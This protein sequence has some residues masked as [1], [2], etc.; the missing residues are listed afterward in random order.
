[1]IRA[2]ESTPEND[3]E[4]PHMFSQNR[5]PARA[6]FYSFPDQEG[7]LKQSLEN[8]PYYLNL[9]GE[10]AFNFVNSPADRPKDFYQESYDVSN[11]DKIPVPSNWQM[12]GYDTAI[13]VNQ[14]Y[15]FWGIAQEKPQPPI[16]P[17]EYNPVGSY[18]RT[19]TVPENWGDRHVYIH[20]G[21]VKSAFYIWVNGK[22]VGYSEGSKTP[23][24]FDLTDYINPGNNT[25]ALEVYRW[26]SGSYLEAQDFWRLSGITRDVYLEARNKAHIY[27]FASLTTLTDQYKNGE[28]NLDFSLVNYGKSG[29][30]SVEYQLIDPDK[31]QL[32]GKEIQKISLKKGEKAQVSFSK[33]VKNVKAWSAET[34]H[35]YTL[36][37]TLKKK[38][39]VIDVISNSIGFRSVEIKGGQLLVNGKAILIKGVNLHEHHET[40][41]QVVDDETR[42]KDILLM[43]Q[44][45]INT[46]RT[47]HYP[48]DSRWYQ[49][50][51]QYGLYVI[52]EA[53]IE[54]HGMK[55]N[56]EKGGTLG[57][58]PEWELMHIDRT[59][60]M[61][62]RDKN[63]AS[64]IIWSLGN[65]AGNGYNFYRTY[66]WLKNKTERPVQYERA[67]LEWN[68]DI[69]SPM[70]M[71][72][73]NMIKYHE[74]PKYKDRPLIQ[75][76]YAHAMGNSLGNFQDYWDA[77]EKYP[78]LQGG[79]IWDWV[80]QGLVKTND[81]GEK[82]WA[83]GGD[84]GT[85]K[86]S[87]HNFCMNG[88][89]NADRSIH[90]QIHEVKKVYQYIQFKEVDLESKMMQIKNMHDFISLDR[91]QINWEVKAEGKIVDQGVLDLPS[92]AAQT[93]YDVKVPYQI[94]IKEGTEYFLNFTASLKE[95]DGLLTKG[96]QVAFEQMKLPVYQP[97]TASNTE[98]E[99][100]SIKLKESK[101]EAELSND[102]F[103]IH[104]DKNSGYLNSYQIN[105]E[106]MITLAPRPNFWRAPIDNDYGFKGP[107]RDKQW[108]E[109]SQ[110]Q[111]FKYWK[112]SKLSDHTYEVKTIHELAEVNTTFETTYTIHGNG[113]IDVKGRFN[114]TE[115]K[116]FIPRVGLKLQVNPEYTQLK[117]FG[118]GPWENY[119]D[120]FTS[121]FV[122]VYESTVDEQYFAYS[123]P[124]ENGYKTEVRWFSLSK[125]DSKGILFVADELLGFSALNRSIESQ[126]DGD[127]KFL[128]QNH[129]SEV[130]DQGI[131]EIMIDDKQQGVGGDTSWGA[132]PH[133]QY[134]LPSD[135]DYTFKFTIM[136]LSGENEFEMKK[137]LYSN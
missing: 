113:Q 110:N 13:Y 135:Q 121:A 108:K 117:Y 129:G 58:A 84:F 77:F 31:I 37:A 115:D 63:H 20:L 127:D 62:E 132:K 38:D 1:M 36:I 3:L 57:N 118:R 46:V 14:S 81:K 106:E 5:L 51:D 50:C 98:S 48:H 10:W 18:K 93:A 130:H 40:M 91:Y 64:V 83:Y 76:E 9:N 30:Y 80:D 34:P 29:K 102:L 12:Q 60:R 74:N 104:F 89:V 79:C 100:E 52:N 55:Y 78:R 6:H 22:K 49:L 86:P 87:D 137:N 124:Q 88:I 7:A 41:G 99:I 107:K 67:G 75:C 90:P 45:N 128:V 59:E 32:A 47:S 56:L 35:L 136:P 120:R 131:V 109:A 61:Y 103:S 53:N 26:S 17:N 44:N 23:A 11:W 71:G 42:M 16:I 69:F 97:Y 96:F 25:I 116:S 82:I 112:I 4:N 39:E 73:N 133:D 19:F 123:R 134:R 111:T 43:K 126:D 95:N 66:Q 2:Q 8:H 70:Y 68:T 101:Q 105:G 92:I 119:Q 122:D 85:N 114:A 21:A 65:E 125:N 72:I 33:K 54:S 27:D 15:E 24:E 94:N 28:L